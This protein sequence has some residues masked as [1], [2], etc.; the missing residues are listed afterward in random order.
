MKLIYCKSCHD[1]LRL[2]FED[3]TCKCGKSGGKYVDRLNA[4]IWGDAL[5]LGIDNYSFKWATTNQYQEDGGVGTPFTAFVI[6][7]NCKTVRGVQD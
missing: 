5:P 7:K 3:R 2:W 6:P 1:I 4:Q